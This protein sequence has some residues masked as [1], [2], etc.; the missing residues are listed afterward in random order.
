MEY[1]R[2][3]TVLVLILFATCLNTRAA[4]TNSK[5]NKNQE[6]EAIINLKEYLQLVAVHP[7]PDYGKT[8]TYNILKLKRILHSVCVLPRIDR[9][10]YQYLII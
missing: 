2:F 7:E 5:P 9:I 10:C 8:A 1:K 4:S 3:T 6:D